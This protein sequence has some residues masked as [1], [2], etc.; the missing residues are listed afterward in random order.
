MARTICCIGCGTMGSAILG[1]LREQ[2]NKDDYVIGGYNRSLE[3]MHA[4][5]NK[6]ISVFGS[7]EDAASIA[8]VLVLAVKPD[9]IMHVAEEAGTFLKNDAILV[10]VAA[11]ISL[12]NLR[13]AIGTKG[14]LC[15]CMPTT[16]AIVGNGLFAV[17]F[18]PDFPLS[19]KEEI[20]KLFGSIGLCIPIE[21]K[22][23]TDF[24]ALIGAGPAYVFQ[25]M[26][27]LVQA[28]ITLGFGH[29][30]CR[31]MVSSLFSGAAEMAKYSS[32]SLMQLRDEVCSPAGLTIAGVNILDK[33]G[34]VG[35]LV[36]AV[37]AARKR[38]EEM[39]KGLK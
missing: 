6:G 20:F 39:E 18:D 26:Q 16:T 5:A 38:A 30:Q 21:E 4:L 2:L 11:G 27:G 22:M 9:Q 36:D 25:M 31:S 15:R 17:C 19:S 10:S 28:G 24:S 14:H 3:K 33:A 35:I 1:G 23:M 34:L 29:A 8:D 7:L 13:E 32:S 12:A 37:M